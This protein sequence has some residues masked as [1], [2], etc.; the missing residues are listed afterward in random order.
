[1]GTGLVVRLRRLIAIRARLRRL[2]A[3]AATLI[4]WRTARSAKLGEDLTRYCRDT[5]AVPD[6]AVSVSVRPGSDGFRHLVL[7]R[8]EENRLSAS[9]V[10][11]FLA[12]DHDGGYTRLSTVL[13]VAAR[14]PLA[15][16]RAVADLSDGETAGPGCLGFCSR[17]PAAILVPDPYFI[18]NTGY[19]ELRGVA[20]ETAWRDRGDR[21]V[22]RGSTT[23]SGTIA[24]D[25]LSPDDPSLIP[26]VRLCLKLQDV[27]AADV[28]ISTIVQS[29]DPAG[30]TERLARAG[31]MGDF[32][33]PLAWR[34]FK[35]A[36]DIDG[37]TNAWQNLFT[38]L[39]MG[40][41]VLKVASPSN[42]R[43][44]YYEDLKPWI[45]YIPVKADLS[46]L[47]RQ[48][49]WCRANPDACERVAADGQAFAMARDYATEVAAAV[50]RVCAAFRRGKL[51]TSPF[52]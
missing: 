41:C 49:A 34:G 7:L 5:L 31:I 11:R 40:C 29:N 24:T 52:G 14:V 50:E 6:I 8:R 19:H 32:I 30:D 45:H 23:G 28:K 9:C 27:P 39:L 4:R 2:R 43:Q 42:F 17:D 36:I 33:P 48:I 22:W 18:C 13:A 38:R 1:M 21:I 12:R 46:D 35:F 3:S 44:W 37:N 51:C 26:R 25:E 20:Q 16:F 15:S 10:D 47:G